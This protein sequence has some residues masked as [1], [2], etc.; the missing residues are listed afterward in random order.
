VFKKLSDRDAKFS[1]TP[2]SGNDVVTI[3]EAMAKKKPPKYLECSIC[4]LRAEYDGGS[5]LY[6]TKDGLQ[7]G[8]GVT[9]PKCG[10]K[11]TRYL[12]A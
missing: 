4:G 7:L 8:G 6:F 2:L 3:E 5:G 12:K 10:S 9:C 11:G 1:E